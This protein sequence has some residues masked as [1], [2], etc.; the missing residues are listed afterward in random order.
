MSLLGDAREAYAKLGRVMV[1]LPD[2]PGFPLG[3]F[4]SIDPAHIDELT[5]AG[6]LHR[7]ADELWATDAEAFNQAVD[8][9]GTTCDFCCG[10]TATWLYPTQGE[11]VFAVVADVETADRLDFTDNSDWLA[12]DV[13][14]QLIEQGDKDELAARAARII[15]EKH[16]VPQTES[17]MLASGLRNVQSVFFVRRKGE[18]LPL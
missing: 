15:R 2:R 9:L 10:E 3:A 8:A 18:R 4:R 12:C 1:Q 11:D 5:A 14:S 17:L 13:C 16:D 6:V 7:H